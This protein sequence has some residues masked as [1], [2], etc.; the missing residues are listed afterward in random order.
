MP[1][2]SKGR[3]TELS[4]GT[5]EGYNVVGAWCTER[6]WLEVIPQR[7]VGG[8]CEGKVRK[9]Q[10]RLGGWGRELSLEQPQQ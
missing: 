8:I 4:K 10:A 6:W 1:S 7:Q 3:G 9:L 5:A 2:L